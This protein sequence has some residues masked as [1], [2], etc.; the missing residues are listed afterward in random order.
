M[1]LNKFNWI[2]R[3][4]FQHLLLK[5]VAQLTV[6]CTFFQLAPVMWSCGIYKFWLLAHFRISA[7]AVSS[8]YYCIMDIEY[9]STWGYTDTGSVLICPCFKFPVSNNQYSIINTWIDLSLSAFVR[10]D[11]HCWA[12]HIPVDTFY[13]CDIDQTSDH[14]RK[15]M[16]IVFFIYFPFCHFID[17]TMRQEKICKQIVN[18]SDTGTQTPL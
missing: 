15:T 9:E 17:G 13:F 10:L 6:Q 18:D 5:R 12:S 4:N 7:N 1:L 16:V 14:L 11:K 2:T 3:N 8:G